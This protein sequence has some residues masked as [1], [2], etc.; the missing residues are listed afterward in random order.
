[1]SQVLDIIETDSP[2]K[3]HFFVFRIVAPEREIVVSCDSEEEMVSWITILKDA[4]NA[5]K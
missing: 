3:V 1:L 4:M 5:S 2:S